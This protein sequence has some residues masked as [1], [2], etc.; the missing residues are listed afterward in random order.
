MIKAKKLYFIF[1][2]SVIFVLNLIFS[3]SYFFIDES[4]KP[5]F[6]ANNDH[7]IAFEWYKTWSVSDHDIGYGITID[8]FD[9]IIITGTVRYYGSTYNDIFLIKFNNLGNSQWGSI[10]GS[11]KDDYG[12]EVVTDNIGNVYVMGTTGNYLAE[13]S[14]IIL[15]KINNSG[16]I[17]WNIKW[18]SAIY[19]WGRGIDIDDSG[20]IYVAGITN[21]IATGKGD[22]CF[23]KFDNSG[24][25]I[26]NKTYGGIESD[27][28]E[29]IILDDYGNIYAI[30][31][32]Y[33]YG[34]GDCNIYLLKLNNSG[35]LEWYTTWG[36]VQNEY[37][38][39][40]VLDSLGNIYIVGTYSMYQNGY[41]ND[42]LLLKFD[43]AGIIQWNV[44][45]GGIDS[46]YGKKVT[47]DDLGNLFVLGNTKSYGS[48]GY[49]ACILKFDDSGHIEWETTWGGVYD[50]YGMDLTFDSIGN[51][52]ITGST[53]SYSQDYDLMLIKYG[54]DSDNDGLSD[55]VE[56]N[57]Y[58]TNPNN[59]DTD[60]DKLSDGD[61]ILNFLTDPNKWDTDGDGY[62][63]YD[64]IFIYGTNPNNF[65]SNLSILLMLSLLILIMLIPIVIF[66]YLKLKE[67]R[68]YK[69]QKINK[70]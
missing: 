11:N 27:Y 43:N 54:V 56:L 16:I 34:L 26:W 69:K 61:E 64:E 41:Y 23:I 55:Y 9:N 66:S 42:L 30:G 1:F 22:L 19:N 50:D 39:G 25:I 60:N 62:S 3:A 46:D 35:N 65:Y 49:D 15:S 45:W 14:D 7:C 12:D 48:G 6:S 70:T 31:S 18:G 44:S 37:G 51:L 10:W 2:F 32:T 28:C 29:Q 59:S 33:S 17:Q 67:R 53:E 58:S 24:N 57:L 5:K 38:E 40:I 8:N 4:Q 20:N 21:D 13:R 63:D 68:K 52:Y 47:L 36:G